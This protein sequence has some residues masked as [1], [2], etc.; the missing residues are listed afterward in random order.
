MQSN[1]TSSRKPR[2]AAAD[3]AGQVPEASAAAPVAK[4]RKPA[5]STSPKKTAKAAAPGTRHR[6]T[7][8]AVSDPVP[9]PVEQATQ[10]EVGELA[11]APKV[12]AA[13]SGASAGS[14][15]S[16]AI[17]SVGQITE[18]QAVGAA[19]VPASERAGTGLNAEEVARLAHSY[20]VARGCQHGS[21]EEDWLRAEQELRS[22]R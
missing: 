18:A 19:N 15:H 3:V 16:D 7:A 5:A 20:W 10:A 4:T 11:A 13:A 14:L 9:A 6:K 22:R 17:S 1:K 8:T 2:E 12:M 21:H